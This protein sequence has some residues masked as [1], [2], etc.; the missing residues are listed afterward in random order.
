MARQRDRLVEGAGALGEGGRD[1]LA[2]PGKFIARTLVQ[3]DEAL[4]AL[5]EQGGDLFAMG[6]ERLGR[7]FEQG[8][9]ARGA[10]FEQ[11]GDLFAGGGEGF[12]QRGAMHGDGVV[13]A[14]AGFGDARD[15][16]LAGRCDLVDE[17]R[18]VFADGQNETFASDAE[19]TAEFFRLIAERGAD[20]G[21]SFADLI[22]DARAS[23]GEFARD[24]FLRLRHHLA[25]AVGVAHD[26]FALGGELID[27]RAHAPFVVGIGSLEV[28]DLVVDEHFELAGARQRTLDAIAHGRDLAADRLRQH[29]HLIG[30]KALG[31]GKA[32]CHLAHGTRRVTHFLDAPRQGGGDEE[33]GGRAEAGER[34]K[35]DLRLGEGGAT[36]RIGMEADKAEPDGGGEE[37]CDGGG[38]AGAILQGLKNLADRPAIVIGGLGGGR[39]QGGGSLRGHGRRRLT[40]AGLAA[41]LGLE[42]RLEGLGAGPR[43]GVLVFDLGQTRRLRRLHLDGGRL[44]R[45]IGREIQRF[46]ACRQDG[47]RCVLTLR[48][49][50]HVTR[51]TQSYA[52]PV[53]GTVPRASGG[54][55]CLR[56]HFN[57]MEMYL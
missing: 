2:D 9:G 13:D 37:G 5:I 17:T 41:L 33:E 15:E 12:I 47:I 29:H 24:G 46:L 6:G 54:V 26:G 30:G 52:S 56:A 45:Q 50:R 34:I 1:F 14:V 48:L 38:I 57:Q 31:I 27:Q 44:M 3:I 8:D 42:N 49:Y 10:L 11:A 35:G 28:R 4:N 20:A 32:D 51:L 43:Q 36:L 39:E 22:G 23:L 40:L 7:G 19:V 25:N 55:A 18:S 21:A 53:P 16:A